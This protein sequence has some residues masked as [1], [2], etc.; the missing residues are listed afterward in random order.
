MTKLLDQVLAR[1][2]ALPE[3]EQDEIAELVAAVLHNKETASPLT[4]EQVDEVKRTQAAV[5]RG[6][7]ATDEEMDELWRRFGLA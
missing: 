3:Q 7:V 5:R 1:L 2:R 6:E 4:D